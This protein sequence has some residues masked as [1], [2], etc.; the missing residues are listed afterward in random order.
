LAPAPAIAGAWIAPEGGQE[1]WT[2]VAGERAGLSFFESAG[3]LEAPLGPNDAIVAAPWVETN[4]DTTDGWR[5]EATLSFKHA[6]HRGED[7]AMA[8]QAGALWMSHP[9][10]GCSEGGVELRWLGG[11]NIGERS[12]LNLEAAARALE[13]GCAGARIELT[14]GYRPGERWLGMAQLFYDGP[15][16][17]DESVKAQLTLVRFSDR[18]RAIQIG[19]RARV[20]GEDPEPA[21]IVSFWGRPG[22]RRD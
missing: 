17:G 6:L 9:N 19:V 15:L 10:A 7:S 22:D 12:F 8:I 4:Y 5:A 14:A 2:S 3:Y 1:I 21:L 20:D 13:G 18:G 16:D 11:R